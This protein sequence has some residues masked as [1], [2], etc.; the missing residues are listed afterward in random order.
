MKDYEDS[1]RLRDLRRKALRLAFKDKIMLNV[2]ISMPIPFVFAR[3]MTLRYLIYGSYVTRA[4]GDDPTKK[5]LIQKT[6]LPFKRVDFD[7]LT[8]E[9]E[10]ESNFLRADV[11]ITSPEYN[12]EYSYYPDKPALK[13]LSH[14]AYGQSLELYEVS[15][16]ETMMAYFA[17][18]LSGDDSFSKERRAKFKELYALHCPDILKQYY[19]D[20]GSDFFNWVGLYRN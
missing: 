8:C 7:F 15:Y 18:E 10:T 6:H 5:D 12:S 2:G 4:N 20:A 3:K 13:A 14:E 11:N 17:Y 9:L 1:Y 16:A 19:E